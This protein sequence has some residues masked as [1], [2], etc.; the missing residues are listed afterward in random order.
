MGAKET[1]DKLFEACVV[2]VVRENDARRAREVA[3]GLI[4]AG[5]RAL[6]ITAGT[7]GCFEILEELGRSKVDCVL[8]VGT[9]RT[10]KDLSRAVEAGARFL[11]SPHTDPTIIR[12]TKDVGCV[13]IP[14]AMTPTEVL[15]A[16]KAGADVVKIFPISAVGGPRYL[17][18]LRGPIPD[19]PLW[20]SGTVA[21]DEIE[22]YLEEG[23]S[24]VGL[25]SALG[26]DP[27]DVAEANAAVARFRARDGKK[28]RDRIAP[29]PPIPR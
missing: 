14:G 5:I 28:E 1:L 2:A 29:K 10:R 11:V 6:E 27:S 26:N 15:A 7:P 19:V 17:R 12:E 9:I 18:Q 23:V 21:L 24:L 22:G 4:A 8:G 25:T 16:R 20:V 13:S 3:K